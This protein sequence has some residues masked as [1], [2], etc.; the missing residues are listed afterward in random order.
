MLEPED[1][2]SVD[3]TNSKTVT[4][5]NEGKST[6]MKVEQKAEVA[7]NK[8]Q[9]TDAPDSG[10]ISDII[11]LLNL[12]DKE[13]GGKGEITDVPKSMLGS[14]KYLVDKLTTI[15]DIF[16]DPL[17]AAIL[18][19]MVD[20]AEDGKT[21]SVQVAIA[22]NVPLSSLQE[23]ADNEEYETIQDE[24]AEELAKSKNIEDEDAKYEEGFGKSIEAG[25]KYAQTMGYDETEQNA[26]F[27]FMLD[28]YKML[29]DGIL[30]EKEWSDADKLRNYDRD[31]ADL[32]SQIK[33]ASETK[34]V[35]PDKASIESAIQPKPTKQTQAPVNAPGMGS[36]AAYMNP[37][38]DV[39]AVRGQGRRGMK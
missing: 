11:S 30:T 27:Q 15:K 10:D 31:I 12:L 21:P 26:L 3:V 34:E 5:D 6:G 19:D 20:Q 28:M 22:R 39:T 23:L 8:D 4:V 33:P 14:I 18:E 7:P 9:T 36:M 29:G 32:K 16:A 13:T 25:K 37:T 38:T 2:K 24:L 17:F 35:L 1:N